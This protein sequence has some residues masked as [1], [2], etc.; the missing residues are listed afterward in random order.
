MKYVVMTFSLLS[1]VM[2]MIL[3]RMDLHNEA[4]PFMLVAIW[5]ELQMRG[6]SK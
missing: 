5:F 1:L 4:T 2:G 3:V 6:F